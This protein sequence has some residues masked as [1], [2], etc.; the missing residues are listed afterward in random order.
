MK[1]VILKIRKKKQLKLK[2]EKNKNI[3]I[4]IGDDILK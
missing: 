4:S 1:T 2:I 3:I